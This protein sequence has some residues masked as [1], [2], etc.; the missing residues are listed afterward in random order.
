MKK[1]NTNL[2]SCLQ[3][4]SL[5]NC[6]DEKLNTNTNT[7]KNK[8]YIKFEIP[9][10]DNSNITSKLKDAESNTDI[11]FDEEFDLEKTQDNET[12]SSN[13]IKS[14]II[15]NFDANNSQKQ[16]DEKQSI[17]NDDILNV[18]IN[19]DEKKSENQVK[20]QSKFIK[21][22]KEN[23][24]F[25]LVLFLI[26]FINFRFPKY[27]IKTGSM[28]PALKIGSVAFIDPQKEP[29]VADIAAYD[30]NGT[31]IIHRVMRKTE[32]GYVFKGDANNT[33]DAQIVTSDKIKGTVILKLNFVSPIVQKIM[34]LKN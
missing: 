5:I 31:T 13:K 3:D 20:Q 27:F 25:F 15:E 6:S 19:K 18:T 21:F 34:H 7:N 14:N 9:M 23:G 26:I 30:C 22:I 2:G 28:E 8:E 10:L 1:E 24:L 32:D 16:L 11:S 12:D 4:N 29:Q 33:E 17:E